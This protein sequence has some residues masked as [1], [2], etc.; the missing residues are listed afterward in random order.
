MWTHRFSLATAVATWFLLLVGGI[1]HG[2]GASLACPDWPLCFGQFFPRMEGNIL[3]EHGHRLFASSV[4]ILTVAL[5]VCSL[6]EGRR[7]HRAVPGLA[8]LALFLVIVQGVLG[9]LT[10]IYRLPTLISWAH[11]CTSMLFFS[12][13]VAIACLTRH[14]VTAPGSVFQRDE[15]PARSYGLLLLTTGLCYVQI[16]LGGLVR[17]TG[18]GLA[19]LDIPLCHGS[20]LPLSDHP[21]VIL[22]AV[23]RLHGLVFAVVLFFAMPQLRLRLRRQTDG[24][25]RALS[26]ALPLGVLLQIAL[27]LLSVWNYLALFY[28]TAHLGLGALLLAGLVVLCFRLR[29]QAAT[30]AAGGG[31]VT[32]KGDAA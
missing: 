6:R 31:L 1:V 13:V 30:T 28:V 15:V 5:F 8:G 21:T 17:H 7:A 19:C 18:G 3:V 9:G 26:V 29:A 4:G 32:Q 11:L 24:V 2:T 22:H 10:V 25:R 20:V 16:A 14:A 23:H 12:T 27:G